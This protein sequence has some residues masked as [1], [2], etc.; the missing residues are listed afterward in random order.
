MLRAPA[1]FLQHVGVP[2]TDIGSH[3][4]YGVYHSVFDNY[5]WY[6]L[7]ADP[8]FVYLQEMARILGLEALHMADT[9]VLPYDYVTYGKEIEAYLETAKKKK[10]ASGLDFAAAES[11]AARFT[12][13]A[14]AV[15]A[16]QANPGA[17]SATLNTTLR[18]TEADFINPAGLPN[19][20]W[21]KHTIYA[22]GEY[23]GYAAVVIPGVN[24]AIDAKNA[25]VA[26]E[27]L[28][29]LTK[30]LNQAAQTLEGAE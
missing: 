18:A 13:A 23:T 15:K 10:S 6:T 9:D 21:Y 30:S 8:T 29:V 14:E 5:A 4:D 16:K 26:A 28:T 19:R 25:T 20:G 17:N 27:Q 7:N 11:A 3:G 24:E 2:S 12:K 1:P 22:P